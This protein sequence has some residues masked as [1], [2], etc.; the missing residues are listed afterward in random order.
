MT[1][2]GQS[3]VEFTLI[4]ILVILGIVFM[5][6]YVLRSI[7][8]YFKLWDTSV[9][10]S[11]EEKLQQAPVSDVPDILANCTYVSTNEGCGISVAGA[12]CGAGYSAW[13]LVDNP[14]G[15]SGAPS[16]TCKADCGCCD[17]EPQG[18]GSFP[19]PTDASGNP[20]APPDNIPPPATSNCYYGQ[21]LLASVCAPGMSCPNIAAPLCINDS[22]CPMPTCTGTFPSAGFQPCPATETGLTADTSFSYVSDNNCASATKKCQ[23]VCAA[24]YFPNEN[25]SYIY[26]VASITGSSC[27]SDPNCSCSCAPGGPP[28]TC[29][30]NCSFPACTSA[31]VHEIIIPP[32]CSIAAT[33]GV[34]CTNQGTGCG[35][36]YPDA[37]P[38]DSCLLELTYSITNP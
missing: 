36:P 23:Y 19:L 20:I 31:S 25:C 13:T 30:N 8:A 9:Q 32:S 33:G 14:Q 16:S 21:H 4:A 7:N 2:R 22:A 24:G 15:C 28:W 38:S 11:F 29:T 27:P 1:R 6:P 3:I 34:D 35:D 26:T 18:C 37:I 5:G 10:D 12:T 17:P